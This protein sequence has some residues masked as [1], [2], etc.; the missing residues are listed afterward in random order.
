M[1]SPS[2]SLP[3]AS[4]PV[5]LSP[6][7]VAPPHPR[8]PWSE[9]H[10]RGGGGVANNPLELRKDT[11]SHARTHWKPGPGL[12]LKTVEAESRTQNRAWA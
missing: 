3:P 10:C 9:P 1:S 4:L 11:Q 8:S 7:P 2:E 6:R 12:G 5:S